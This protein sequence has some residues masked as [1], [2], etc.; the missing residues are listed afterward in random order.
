MATVINSSPN[1]FILTKSLPVFEKP[2]YGLEL[3]KAIEST[4]GLTGKTLCVQKISGL[5]RIT[6][7]NELARATLLTTGVSLRGH[8]VPVLGSNP[9]LVNGKETIR[10]SIS[11]FPF[12]GSSSLEVIQRELDTLNVNMTSKLQYNM[13]RDTNNKLTNCSNGN[14]FVYIIAPETPLPKLIKV[15]RHKVFLSYPGQDEALN[16]KEIEQSKENSNVQNQRPV[17]PI[18]FEKPVVTVEQQVKSINEHDIPSE[19]G[20]LPDQQRTSTVPSN[21]TCAA[22]TGLL[23][24]TPEPLPLADNLSIN[25]PIAFNIPLTKTPGYK[26][27]KKS[28]I[29]K[30]KK[31]QLT[32]HDLNKRRRKSYKTPSR[33]SGNSSTKRI[34]SERESPSHNANTG[35]K[36]KASRTV[37]EEHVSSGFSE[38][39]A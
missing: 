35:N 39:P 38:K 23:E 37:I 12:A 3:L 34:F 13:Y 29:N 21:L 16:A 30:L 5:W 33:P 18:P 2:I 8:F 36:Q 31:N 11:N 22:E 17:P 28:T 4:T 32:L 10:L 19:C 15:D 27:R 24:D 26:T 9:F 1:V 25:K 14:M 6:L 7:S 20:D